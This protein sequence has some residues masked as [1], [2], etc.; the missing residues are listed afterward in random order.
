[1]GKKIVLNKC[2]GGFGLS[3]E[4][5]RYLGYLGWDKP[6]EIPRDDPRLIQVV[7]EL[8][9][10]ANGPYAELKVIEIPDGVPW[11]IDDYDGYER[12]INPDYVY[13]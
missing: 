12:C 8:R 11:E 4:A 5:R 1:M 7:E 3:G 13:G 10:K 9:E 2:Y 6:H